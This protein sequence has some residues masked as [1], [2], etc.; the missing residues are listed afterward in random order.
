MLVQ[1]SVSASHMV[2]NQ[3]C[4][5]LAGRISGKLGVGKLRRRLAGH[6][7]NRKYLRELKKVLSGY[8][9]ECSIL[10]LGA[11]EYDNLGDHAIIHAQK[12]FLQNLVGKEHVIEIRDNL[13][14]HT[15][16]QLKQRISPRTVITIPGGG[17]MGDLWFSDEQRRRWI[18]EDFPNNPIVVFPQ[19]ISYSDTEEGQEKL[20]ESVKLYNAHKNLTLC[21][22]E[23]DSYLQMQKLYPNNKILLVPDI[24]LSLPVQ[25]S[26]QPRKDIALCFRQDAERSVDKALVSQ[27]QERLKE[28]GLPCF[29]I[30]TIAPQNVSCG[31]REKHLNQLW[32]VLSSAQGCITDRLHGMIFCYITHTPCLALDNQN[33]KIRRTYETWLKKCDYIFFA[34][35]DTAETMLDTMLSS[36]PGN[37]VISQ[38]D[39]QQLE[40]TIRNG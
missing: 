36:I 37:P 2:C 23:Q 39:Y 16:K 34:Q 6:L 25:T 35:P 19:T 9:P 11:I 22:R 21:A 10:L 13:Y 14:L 24:V 8:E 3:K 40:A 28:K 1:L 30:S 12:Q 15:R 38:S 5:L 20:Q 7:N 26:K 27:L 17:N 33:H 29:P 4:Y 31:S 32:Q 18:L